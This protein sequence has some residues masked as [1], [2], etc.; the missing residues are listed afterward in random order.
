MI[1]YQVQAL[2]ELAV[3]VAHFSSYPFYSSKRIYFFLF[4]EDYFM[5]KAGVHH[6]RPGVVKILNI[7]AVLKTGLSASLLAAYPEVTPIVLPVFIPSVTDILHPECIA[8]FVSGDGSFGLNYSQSK[9]HKLCYSC[10]SQFRIAQYQRD[11]N[12]L[13]RIAAQ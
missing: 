2:I 11:L 10:R 9:R 13:N 12:F 4:R 3:I 7:Q 6:T 1:Y 8:G 5:L